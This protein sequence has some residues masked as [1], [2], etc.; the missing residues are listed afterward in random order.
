[1][2]RTLS[3]DNKFDIQ[4][5]YR[6]YLKFYDLHK[7]HSEQY[8][9]SKA[10][11]VWIAAIVAVVF[12]MGSS[13]FMGVAAGLFGLYFYRVIRAWADKSSAEESRESSERWFATKDLKFEGRI[14]YQREDAMLENPLNPFDDAE[15]S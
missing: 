4:Q 1:M 14:L 10:S 13:F 3:I 7:M 15:Y 12:A 11:R 5:N 9:I 6:R 8:K 2:A